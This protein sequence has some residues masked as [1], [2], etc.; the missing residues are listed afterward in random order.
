MV[1]AFSLYEGSFSVDASKAFVPFDPKKDDPL[2]RKGSI[3]VHVH[4]FLVVADDG[5]IVCDTGLGFREANGELLIHENIRR[6]GYEPEDVKYVLMSHLHKDHAGGMV[7]FKDGVA[8]IAFPNAEYVVQRGEWEYAFSGENSSYKTE[9]FDVI[10]RSG[11]LL[12]V[13]GDG[14]VNEQISYVLNGAHTP[15]HQAFH[16]R[17][18]GAHYFFGGDVLPEPEEIFK[19]F[20]AKYDY[21]GRLARDLRQAYWLE[22]RAD[23]WIYLFYHSKSIAIGKAEQREDGS[24]KII[25]VSI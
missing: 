10:Q 14:A 22:G 9:I 20:I 4:P 18:G 6:K 21:D 15:F 17:T 8:R 11:N 13:D 23:D 25:D 24:F 19:N 2:T 7:D 16:I 12:L 1:Q 5:L 3:F